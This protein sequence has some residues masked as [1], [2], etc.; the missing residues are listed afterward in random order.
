VQP[1]RTVVVVVDDT[2][3][4]RKRL[5]EMLAETECSAPGLHLFGPHGADGSPASDPLVLDDPLV[6]RL[7]CE[8]PIREAQDAAV[9][10]VT[11]TVSHELNQPLA[12]LLGLFELRAAGAFAP[13]QRDEL[14]DE[15]HGAAADLAA[16]LDRLSRAVRFTTK[17]LAGYDFLDVEEAQ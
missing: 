16:R 8:R 17:E 12:L 4:A 5:R 14:L 10:T 13:E 3:A 15:L 6:V 7:L 9:R 1:N 11:R 2:P